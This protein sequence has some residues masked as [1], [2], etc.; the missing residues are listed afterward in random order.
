V[1]V[2][3]I[4]FPYTSPPLTLNQRLNRYAKASTT[5]QLRDLTRIK[6]RDIPP[7][8]H[9]MVLLTWFVTD[10]TR[11]DVDNIVATLKVMCDGLVDA[12]VVEDDT[13][14]FMKKLMPEIV[15][16][17]KTDGPARLELRI[18]KIL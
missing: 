14:Y 8:G 11:R 7:L 6:A 9:C 1:T 2:Y 17:P 10:K 4:H 18:E 3:T 16:I 5:R 12:D 15:L 13:P